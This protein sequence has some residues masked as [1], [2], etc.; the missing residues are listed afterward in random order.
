M[1][2]TIFPKIFF[3]T[4]GV[5]LSYQKEIEMPFLPV[6]INLVFPIEN[7][8]DY[9]LN[10]KNSNDKFGRTIVSYF[11]DVKT[12]ITYIEH[13]KIFKTAYKPLLVD[14]IT[15]ETI[16]IDSGWIVLHSNDVIESIKQILNK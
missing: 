8:N 3:E 5:Q 6:S 12:Q 10:L 1:K 16:L 15:N 11:Y 13:L 14:I 4:I 9:V 2:I 7:G